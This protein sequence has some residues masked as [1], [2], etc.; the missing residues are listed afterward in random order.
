MN[1][2]GTLPL[3]AAGAEALG[4]RLDG[5]QL[6]LLDRHVALLL[7]WNRSIN[8]TAITEPSEVVEKH[9][10]DS[11]AL[12]PFVPRGTLL[13]VGTGAGFP[14]LPVRIAR[15]D[16]ALVLVDS[17]QKKVAFLKSALAELRLANVRALAMRLSGD[18]A[19]EGLS[20]VDGAVARAFAAPRPW[21]RLAGN[22]VR[23]GGMVLCMLGAR[24]EAPP[25]EGELELTGEHEYRLPFSGAQR[26]LRMYRRRE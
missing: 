22:Y 14:G 3:I 12:V 23:P 11:L 13:D 16:L 7:K 24:D 20:L 6:R 19:R 8:L 1:R 21:L 15:P 5:E 9:V 26:R 10:L 4:L 2:D 18:P 25:V 17:V